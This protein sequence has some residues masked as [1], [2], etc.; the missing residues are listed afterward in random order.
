MFPIRGNGWYPHAMISDL[1]QNEI[2]NTDAI[3]YVVYSSLTTPK[4]YFYDFIA[5]IY[6]IKDGYDKLKLIV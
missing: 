3:R 5:E 4:D 6:S 1:I 2:I